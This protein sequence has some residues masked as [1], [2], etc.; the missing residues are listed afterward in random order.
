MGD[1]YRAAQAIARY[2]EGAPMPRPAPPVSTA[3]AVGPAPEESGEPL[4]RVELPRLPCEQ[5]VA[6]FDEVELGMDLASAIGEA[7]RCLRCGR[8]QRE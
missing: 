7:R 2:L 4:A 6:C 3:V 1:G 8:E 5:R